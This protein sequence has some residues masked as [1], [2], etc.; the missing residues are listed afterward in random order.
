MKSRAEYSGIG[1]LNSLL[2]APTISLTVS[3]KII[4][5]PRKDPYIKY[6]T[7]ALKIFTE[8]FCSPVTYTVGA[9]V[10]VL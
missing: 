4:N 1:F 9:L 5:S 2:Q 8:F 7:K 6:S 10:L 3:Y